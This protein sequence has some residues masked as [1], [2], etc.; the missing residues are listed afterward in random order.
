MGLIL[1]LPR[2]PADRTSVA[3]VSISAYTDN[4]R[5]KD[6]NNTNANNLDDYLNLISNTATPQDLQSRSTPRRSSPHFPLAHT[7]THKRR[8]QH[9]EAGEGVGGLVFAFVEVS[10]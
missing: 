3:T 4:Q 2:D 5:N 8:R 9:R 7:H 6:T 1:F 10:V